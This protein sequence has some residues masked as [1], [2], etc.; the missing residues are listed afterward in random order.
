MG[1]FQAMKSALHHHW[2]IRGKQTHIQTNLDTHIYIQ[3]DSYLMLK[4][5]KFFEWLNHNIA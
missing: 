5:H 4:S 3:L 2:Q 1:M